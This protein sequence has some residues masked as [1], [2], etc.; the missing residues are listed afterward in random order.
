VAEAVLTAAIDR[1]AELP[2][3]LERPR[4]LRIARI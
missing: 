4:L 1:I 2:S 3:V